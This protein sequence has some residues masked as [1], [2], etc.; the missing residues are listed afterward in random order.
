MGVAT[1]CFHDPRVNAMV[2]VRSLLTLVVLFPIAF[3]MRRLRPPRTTK[4]PT[5]VGAATPVASA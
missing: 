2:I 4:Q 5:T 1:Q 3:T